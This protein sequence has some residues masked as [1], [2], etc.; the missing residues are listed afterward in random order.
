VR[1]RLWLW[2]R[3]A[4]CMQTK[5][6][7]CTGS[8]LEDVQ[9]IPLTM[10]FD[11]MLGG[12][13]RLRCCNEVVHV[14]PDALTPWTSYRPHQHA[15][16][17]DSVRCAQQ[18][19]KRVAQLYGLLRAEPSI[20][21]RPCRRTSHWR[22]LLPHRPRAALHELRPHRH[23]ARARAGRPVA[24]DRR[25]GARAARLCVQRLERVEPPQLVAHVI[26]GVLALHA[27]RA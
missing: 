9:S 19:T 17:T 18:P 8:A 15:L 1:E 11:G 21:S 16:P 7:S 22:Q 2:W 25:R 5:C 12:Q 3:A 4:P 27:H 6:C 20:I 13:Y 10:P 23:A 26:C 14:H 24:T